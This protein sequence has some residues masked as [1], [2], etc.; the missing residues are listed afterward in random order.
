MSLDEIRTTRAESSTLLEVTLQKL[1]SIVD[2][3]LSGQE[4]CVMKSVHSS[5]ET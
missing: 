4:G 5:T 2:S 1:E 3:K